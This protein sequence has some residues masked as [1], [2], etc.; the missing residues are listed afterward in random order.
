MELH[1]LGRVT[2]N[3]LD[4]G[5]AQRTGRQN[6][7]GQRH[8]GGRTNHPTAG[9]L[10]IWA[11]RQIIWESGIDQSGQVNER[12]NEHQRS[13]QQSINERH[14][15]ERFNELNSSTGKA[16]LGQRTAERINNQRSIDQRSIG[17]DQHPHLTIITPT[18]GPTGTAGHNG[19]N[20][21]GLTRSTGRQAREARRAA[22][23]D[24][25][26][27]LGLELGNPNWELGG[28]TNWGRRQRYGNPNPIWES[29]QST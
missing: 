7:L 12:N 20:G 13:D 14:V 15:N 21:R 6:P 5:A 24:P 18:P 28:R 3:Q 1:V 8:L 2:G 19:K 29:N 26:G 27:Q 9:H 17:I 11:G 4:P 22:G 10:G 25:L 23:R 16:H